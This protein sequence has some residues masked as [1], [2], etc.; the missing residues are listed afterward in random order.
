MKQQSHLRDME[1][2]RRRQDR[3]ILSLT[4]KEEEKTLN[5]QATGTKVIFL[6]ISNVQ[7]GV[8]NHIVE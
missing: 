1:E 6:D 2:N 4:N 3:I 8:R 5:I 7:C